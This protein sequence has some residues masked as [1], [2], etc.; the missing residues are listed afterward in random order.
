MKNKEFDIN[1]EADTLEEVADYL[2]EKF[3]YGHPE[4]TTMT[5]DELDLHSRKNRDYAKDG[6]AL[7]NFNRVAN[8]LSNYPKLNLS[9]PEVVALVYA[10]KQ[11]DAVLWMWN[12][13]YEGQVEG[14]QERL[15]DIH[16]YAKLMRILYKERR[17]REEHGK[18]QISSVN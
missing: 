12:N 16:V 11:L 13:G 4:F 6:D 17:E 8:I 10:M 14:V 3:K 18:T 1:K 5:L 9:N 15:R 2:K 7:G